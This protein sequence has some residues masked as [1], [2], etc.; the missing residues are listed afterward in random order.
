[1]L[2]VF[3]LR[4]GVIGHLKTGVPLVLRGLLVI[5]GMVLIKPACARMSSG[6][7]GSSFPCFF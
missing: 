6:Q 5:A 1:M 4:V 2:G 3:S 7:G